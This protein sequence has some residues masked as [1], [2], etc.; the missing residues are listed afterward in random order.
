MLAHR[1]RR[2]PN[3]VPTLAERLVFARRQDN[4]S[5]LAY[6][7]AH[8]DAQK[9]SFYRHIAFAL[10]ISALAATTKLLIIRVSSA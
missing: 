3:I 7:F 9:Y 2:W 5:S 6:H 8:S 4:L 10:L 1:P